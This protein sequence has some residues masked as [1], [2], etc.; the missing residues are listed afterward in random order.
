MNLRFLFLVIVVILAGAV[1][2]FVGGIVEVGLLA[3]QQ[4]GA[5]SFCEPPT[6]DTRHE[7]DHTAALVERS[8]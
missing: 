1:L 7:P 5:A 3:D 2:F 8:R 6:A 4:C